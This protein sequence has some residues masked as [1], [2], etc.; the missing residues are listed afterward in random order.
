VLEDNILWFLFLLFVVVFLNGS[1][2]CAGKGW[3]GLSFDDVLAQ[4][5]RRRRVRKEALAW[6]IRRRHRHRDIVPYSRSRAND[7][8]RRLEEWEGFYRMETSDEV[9]KTD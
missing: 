6:S 3:A 1:P 9:T 2:F 5:R 4:W 8:E 7:I